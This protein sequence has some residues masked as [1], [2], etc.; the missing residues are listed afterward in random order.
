MP[1]DPLLAQSPYLGFLFI[2]KDD[3][4]GPRGRW[5]KRS[6]VRQ[7]W[8]A[9]HNPCSRQQWRGQEDSPHWGMGLPLRSFLP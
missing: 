7:F 4:L 3:V 9:L 2:I 6:I 8:I 5:W 1:T